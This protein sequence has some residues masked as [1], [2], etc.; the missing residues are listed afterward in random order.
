MT[1][2]TKA[3]LWAIAILAVAAICRFNNV[4]QSETFA[5][6]LG[7]TAAAWA[8]LSNRRCCTNTSN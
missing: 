4:G 8:T 7:L 3:I 5:L 2:L 6:I 1:N